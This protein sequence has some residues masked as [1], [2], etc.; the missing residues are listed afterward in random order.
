VKN[1]HDGYKN[2]NLVAQ[3]FIEGQNQPTDCR[4]HDLFSAVKGERSI[5]YFRGDLW[6]TRRVLGRWMSA[7]T[8]VKRN[9]QD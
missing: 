5:S 7:K 9:I 8:S 1:R 3:Q 2:N 4:P 6:S